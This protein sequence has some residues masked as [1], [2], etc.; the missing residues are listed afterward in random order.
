MLWHRISVVD[1][2]IGRSILFA[3]RY[4]NYH[5]PVFVFA[6]C[7]F[8]TLGRYSMLAYCKGCGCGDVSDGVPCPEV[9][10]RARLV[11]LGNTVAAEISAQAW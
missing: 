10:R 6:L 9:A 5:R 4:D 1:V 7:Q 8:F 2:D 11:K 3:G